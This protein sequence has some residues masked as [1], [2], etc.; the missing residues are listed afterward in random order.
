MA[1]I[2]RRQVLR[3]A[4]AFGVLSG[5]TGA[6]AGAIEPGVRLVTTRYNVTPPNWP[7]GL[8]LRVAVIADIHACEPWMSQTRIRHIA[9]RTN[10]LEPDV[11]VL[12]GDFNGGHRYV[13]DAVYPEQWAEALSILRAPLG[14]YGIL[15][16]HDWWHGALPGMRSDDGESVRAG[17][18]QAGVIHL[19]NAVWAVWKNGRKVWLAGI[20]DQIAIRVGRHRHRGVDD[21]EGTLAQVTDD[22]PLILL[23]H[24][25]YIF[26]RVPDR[27]S[28][29]LCG[30]THGG[31]VNLPIISTLY[32]EDR[33]GTDRIYGHVVENKRNMIISGGLGTSF[34]PVRLFR[35][36]EIVLVTIGEG[37]PLAV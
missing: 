13:T 32:A 18:R 15:G 28:L 20:G 3:G 27:V 29:T 14:V 12:L 25:P 35:P 11:T 33:Y 36:P 7:R 19:E 10:A 23:A 4:S 31:Q 17:L 21:L 9:E 6:Y 22:A 30:H 1:I 5:A 2:T 26:P 8:T 24:E 34:V 16:N 37:D